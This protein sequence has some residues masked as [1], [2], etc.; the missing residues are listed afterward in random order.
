MGLVI[1]GLKVK[2]FL[3]VESNLEMLE[4]YPDVKFIYTI[5]FS[6]IMH[7]TQFKTGYYDGEYVE[8]Y[9]ALSYSM[10]ND[11]R[12]EICKMIHGVEPE[13]IWDNIEK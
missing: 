9:L 1:R 6:P 3:G 10:Y 7:L 8:G 2:E 4:K 5:D 12:Q 13:E 11:F